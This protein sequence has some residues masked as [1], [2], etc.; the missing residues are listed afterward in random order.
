MHRAALIISTFALVALASFAGVSAEAPLRFRPRASARFGAQRPNGRFARLEEAPAQEVQ[1]GDSV[2]A[3]SG[4]SD[5]YHYP[6]P[7]SA[8]YNY[9]KPDQA[10]PLPGEQ[11]A[12]TESTPTEAPTTTGAA[13]EQDQATTTVDP[14]V[15]GSGDYDDATAA[16][17]VDDSLE[18]TTAATSAKLRRRQQLVS[19]PIRY[20]Q[21]SQRL[22]QL[23]ELAAPGSTPIAQ[24]LQPAVQ[25]PVYLINLPESALQQ[26]LLLNSPLVAQPTIQLAPEPATVLLSELDYV[27]KKKRSV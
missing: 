3:S 23:Q 12:E 8:G 10:F 24:P 27:Y 6:K 11:P 19:N 17:A 9:P 21:Y 1:P 26:L 4:S 13:G 2:D 18:A 22:E 7:M 20:T 16:P 15:E 14:G 25:R 5:G